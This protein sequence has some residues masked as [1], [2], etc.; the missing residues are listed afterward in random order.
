MA[1]AMVARSRFIATLTAAEMHTVA[2]QMGV[3]RSLLEATLKCDAP[4]E[5]F[6]KNFRG[7]S[8][9]RLIEYLIDETG[10]RI[11]K[12]GNNCSILCRLIEIVSSIV[13]SL[14]YT[15]CGSLFVV[16]VVVVVC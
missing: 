15:R 7:D 12:S 8:L 13:S 10:L 4:Q 9:K 3:P 14:V 11:S 1:S 16:V 5:S 2:Q 6:E